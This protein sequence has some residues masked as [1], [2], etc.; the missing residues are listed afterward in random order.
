[1]AALL[2]HFAESQKENWK[3]MIISSSSSVFFLTESQKE[4]WKPYTHTFTKAK[5]LV[6]SQKENWKSRN[7]NIYCRTKSSFE[8]QKENWKTW[9]FL[10]PLTLF[11]L[12]ISKREL[13]GLP[14]LPLSVSDSRLWISKRELK[15]SSC[16]LRV[17]GWNPNWISKR[18]LKAYP[19]IME[20]ISRVMRK[21]L[22][23][24][25]ESYSSTQPDPEVF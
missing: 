25:I 21:N 22:K 9:S 20:N 16:F 11:F 23:K 19:V 17:L 7:G 8:S 1:M 10:A 13:K 4:N 2:P 15:V 14:C 12:G 3:I 6:E 24:R 5:S 18:E